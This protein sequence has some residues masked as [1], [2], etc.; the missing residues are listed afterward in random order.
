MYAVI[1]VGG[2]QF[3][4]Q[5]GTKISC[6]KLEKEANATFDV[7]RILMVKNGDKVQVGNPY[8]KGVEVKVKVLGHGRGKKI[9][10]LKY[11]N[12]INYRKHYGHR[13]SFTSLIIEDIK[14]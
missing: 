9:I 7:E 10:G 6:E 4:V 12:K 13:Q 3:S 1:E 2:H 11:K 5:K 8:L 14:S